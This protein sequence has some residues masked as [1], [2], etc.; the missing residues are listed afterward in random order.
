[1]IVTELLLFTVIAACGIWFMVGLPLAYR[2]GVTVAAAVLLAVV[3]LQVWSPD[4]PPLARQQS[5]PKTN[6]L[7]YVS[8]TT[9]RPCHPEQFQSWHD[10]YHRKMTQV[11]TREAV[12][13]PYEA[14]QI[15]GRGRRFEVDVRDG[16]LWARDVDGIALSKHTRAYPGIDP[17]SN[18]PLVEGPI[19]MTTGSHHMQIYWIR[20]DI[21]V[22]RQLNWVWLLEDQRWV[23]TEDVYSQPSFGHLGI[24]GNWAHHCSKC[25]ATGAQPRLRKPGRPIA[26][27]KIG[28][29]G[30]ACEACHGPALEHVSTNRNPANRYASH[31]SGDAD[32][33]IVNPAKLDHTRSAEICGQCHAHDLKAEPGRGWDPDRGL[34]YRP[35][36]VLAKYQVV[37]TLDTLIES[38]EPA[39]LRSDRGGIGARVPTHARYRRTDGRSNTRLCASEQLFNVASGRGCRQRKLGRQGRHVRGR[40]SQ[41]D[42]T[43]GQGH[44]GP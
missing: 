20:D 33:T 27:T 29:L 17:P 1:M 26:D 2:L 10:S 13:A 31:L 24:G 15:E 7:G 40:V 30:I 44:V 5:P 37:S 23:P 43:H 28:E 19:V 21:G 41:P 34:H 42:R 6:Q 11:A 35:G 14:T 38:A 18:L 25:H 12:L 9:C 32:P 8:S 16:Q 36:E 3:A 4:T 22:F 39:L